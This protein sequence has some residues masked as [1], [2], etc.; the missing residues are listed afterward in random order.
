MLAGIALAF[1]YPESQPIPALFETMKLID[2]L[3]SGRA[4]IC[5]A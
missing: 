2:D 3:L 4:V 5:R 1:N